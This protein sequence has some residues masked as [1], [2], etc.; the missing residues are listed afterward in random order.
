MLYSRFCWVLPQGHRCETLYQGHRRAQKPGHLWSWLSP[1]VTIAKRPP[2]HHQEASWLQ[3]AENSYLLVVSQLIVDGCFPSL[4]ATF[5]SFTIILVVYG[6]GIGIKL[7]IKQSSLGT[8]LVVQ[9]LQLQT[10][11]TG[12]QDSILGQATRSHLPQW[13][14]KI[15]CAVTKTWYDQINQSVN[16]KNKQTKDPSYL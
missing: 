15:P 9:W 16:S 5:T 11:N 4:V 7:W 3:S 8:S 2:D 13:K 12:G 14:S 6:E 10:P 1:F